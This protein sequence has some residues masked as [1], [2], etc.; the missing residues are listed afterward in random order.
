MSSPV[1]ERSREAALQA[2]RRID[3]QADEA[4][5]APTE[6][7]VTVAYLWGQADTRLSASVIRATPTRARVV[8]GWRQGDSV[9]ISDITK[10]G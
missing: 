7:A 9:S 8:S 2:A 10:A 5:I 6:L 4:Q 3:P 1:R